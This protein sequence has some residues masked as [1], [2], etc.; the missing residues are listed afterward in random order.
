MKRILLILALLTSVAQAEDVHDWRRDWVT[1]Q[2]GLSDIREVQATG[3][4]KPMFDEGW[5]LLVRDVPFRSLK[6][7]MVIVYRAR[8]RHDAYE[9]IVHQI[10][11]ISSGGSILVCQGLANSEPDGQLVTEGDYVGRVVGQIVRD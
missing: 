1:Q 5:L 6:I 9:L 7:G 10:V 2:V 8:G 11:R 4:M 3:S